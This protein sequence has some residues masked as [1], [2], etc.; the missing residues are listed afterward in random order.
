MNYATIERFGKWTAILTFLF[1]AF[2]IIGYLINHDVEAGTLLYFYIV[3]AG[4][5][6]LIVLLL[7]IITYFLIRQN[8]RRLLITSSLIIISYSVILCI[9]YLIF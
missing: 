7:V 4:I 8:K 5:T 3:F 9:S 6:N 2:L 1:G